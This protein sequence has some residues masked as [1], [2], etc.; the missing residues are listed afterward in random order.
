MMSAMPRKAVN[1]TDSPV[2]INEQGSQIDGKA[3]G[4][5]DPE[6]PYVVAA[7]AAGTLLFATEATEPGGPAGQ[8]DPEVLARAGEL[9]GE[10]TRP[11]RRGGAAG[12]KQ[13]EA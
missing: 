13:Q 5:V 1:P 3:S 4:P 8:P 10:T 11:P 7:V 12:G 2:I 9:A 6:H